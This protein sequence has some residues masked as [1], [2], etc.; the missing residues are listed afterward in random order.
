MR[1]LIV[2]DHKIVRDGL[3]HLLESAPGFEICGE[4]GD[5]EEALALTDS[6][7]PDVL[8]LDLRMPGMGGLECLAELARAEPRPK[9]VVLSMHDDLAFIR[10][11]IELGANGFL[12]KSVSRDELIDA[13]RSVAAGKSYLQYGLARPLIE[14]LGNTPDWRL[15]LSSR[16]RMVLDGLA[17][18]LDNSEIGTSAGISESMVKVE[19][20]AIYAAL[21]VNRRSE[22]VAVGFRVGL[23]S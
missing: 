15:A 9:V 16:Q 11:A 23:L 3:R 22:A 2:D 1:V 20:R 5:G 8:L 18:G 12:V 10:R 19:L 17:A 14:S 21:G 7:A 6:L 13:L 4:A